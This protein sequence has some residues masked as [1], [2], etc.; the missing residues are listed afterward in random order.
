MV[1]FSASRQTRIA[2]SQRPRLALVMVGLPARGKTYIARRIARYLSWLSLRTEVFNV[3][4]YRREF[5]GSKQ[6]HS[7]FDPDNQEA[8]RVRAD[9]AEKA[10]ADLVEWYRRGGEVGIYDATNTTRARREWVKKTLAAEDVHT[11]FVESVCDDKEVIAANIRETK[12]RMPD[13]QDVDAATAIADFER[14][15]AHY[16]RVYEPVQESEGSFVTVFDVGRKVIAHEIRGFWA[17][18]VVYF[19]MN[20]HPLPRPI[21]LTRH[22]ESEFNREERIGGDPGIT[23]KGHAFARALTVHLEGEHA[24]TS[25]LR[26]WT[27]TLRR[28]QETAAA[29]YAAHPTL[30]PAIEFRSLDEIDA[31]ACDGM[32]YDEVSEILPD[33]YAARER[34]KF[35]YRYPRGESY[36]DVIRRLEPVIVELERER[37]PVL[38]ISHQAVL[39]ALY[40]YFVGLAPEACPF[41]DIPLHTV[42]K[43]V[44]STYSC[45][46]TRTRL[47]EMV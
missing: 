23:D 32:S 11:I 20:L 37:S 27:S 3:G 6:G 15:I 35:S 42:I 44:P 13:Y 18:R 21:Y 36:R 2:N 14:R 29:I 12:L 41:L 39:R 10:L 17:A 46:E 16:A 43:L 4:N 26:I 47:A 9:L 24:L 22:G 5:V 19:L 28:T 30:S 33:E 25:E 8:S 31:G 34:D 38:V 7:F 1:D 45:A 40:A